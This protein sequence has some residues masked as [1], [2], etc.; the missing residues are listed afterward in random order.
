MRARRE[1]HNMYDVTIVGAGPAGLS[2][3]LVLGRVRRR[4]LVC[5]TGAGRNAVSR[6]AHNIFTRDGTP[7]AELRR[8][9]RDQLRRYDTVELRDVG[10]ESAS[11]S[12]TGFHLTL[13]DGTRIESKRILL[14][15]GVVDHLPEVEGLAG[16]WG[17]GVYACPFCDGWEHRDEPIAVY[18][19]DAAGMHVASLLRLLSDDVT[20]FTDGPASL[21]DDDHLRL[22]AQKV[23]LREEPVARVEG[24]DGSLAAVV[25]AGGERLPCRALFVRTQQHQ[26]SDLPRQL[27]CAVSAQGLIDVDAQG[28]T[29]VPGVSAAGDM[30]RM[31]QQVIFAA[32]DGATAAFGIIQSLLAADAA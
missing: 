3:A 12:D 32:A 28:R 14:A 13:D 7:P 30:T 6:A 4:V 5:D 9:A 29:S 26:H 20:F 19:R 24:V 21:S 27:G 23:V 8:I 16:F 18:A 22:A 31:Q 15:T 25:L 2:A 17:R 1:V 10:V 11:P